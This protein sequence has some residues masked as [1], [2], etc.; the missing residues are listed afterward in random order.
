MP[1]T[2]ITKFL[3][4]SLA[5]AKGHIKRLQMGICSTQRK[6]AMEPVAAPTP[7]YPAFCDDQYT[8]SLISNIQPFPATNA[9][10]IED[11]NTSSDTYI[12]C[13]AAFADKRTGIIYNNLTGTF[14]FMS[15]DAMLAS[16]LYTI[17][18]QMLFLPYQ[19]QDSVTISFLLPIS[20][21]TTC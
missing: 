14:P 4:P 17:T 19:L 18:K 15:L 5:T 13:F 8:N 9:N 3:N 2:G 6:D 20:S 10:I 12:F 16:L 7:T 1:A 21:N 11:D